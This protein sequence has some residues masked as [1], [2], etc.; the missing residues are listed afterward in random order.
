MHAGL[1]HH[2]AASRQDDAQQRIKAVTKDSAPADGT[3]TLPGV[4]PEVLQQQFLFAIAV[5]E[6]AGQLVEQL[7]QMRQAKQSL[8][9]AARTGMAAA[10]R[11]GNTMT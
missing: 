3:L 11:I 6:G 1:S 9:Q 7:Q 8:L 4:T 10:E 5:Q 2:Q